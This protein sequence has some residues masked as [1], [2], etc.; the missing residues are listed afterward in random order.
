MANLILLDFL[1][2]A[3]AISVSLITGTHLFN[4][5]LD[6]FIVFLPERL[7]IA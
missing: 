2:N 4:R 7:F 6:R 1:L 5:V 3:L